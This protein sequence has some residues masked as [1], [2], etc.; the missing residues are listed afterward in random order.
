MI[1]M[2]FFNIY[3]LDAPIFDISLIISMI[4]FLILFCIQIICVFSSYK[5]MEI[6]MIK[7]SQPRI[8]D[9]LVVQTPSS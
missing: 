2:T 6:A 1:S 9:D 5:Q 8:K 7:F 4:S 3:N